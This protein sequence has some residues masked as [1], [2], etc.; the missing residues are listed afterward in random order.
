M[1]DLKIGDVK[2]GTLSRVVLGVDGECPAV[3]EAAQAGVD[4]L[5]V[6]VD[7]LDTLAPSQVVSEV[8]VLK[9]HEMPLIGTIRSQAE[10]G[11]ANVSDTQRED[12]Y[13][14]ISPLVQAID[15][16]LSSSILK[17]VIAAARR[18]KNTVI[19][20]HHNFKKT[21]NDATLTDIVKKAHGLGAD[22][23]KIAVRANDEGDVVRLLEFTLAHRG[24]NLVTI[25]MG[26]IGS[27]SRLLFPLAGS[28]MT[29]TSVT[30][31]DGQ[32]PPQRLIE[33]LRLYYPR[34]NESV[35]ARTKSLEFA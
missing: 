34:Y 27:V 30:P 35:I 28:V 15:L 16:D 6:R 29:Y 33:D 32:I 5:E 24:K 21:P 3:A 10:G 20:S 11:K 1:P 12:L 22:I 31:S 2:L 23:I 19:L 17:P 18:N 4:I 14:R 13:K 7:L 26:S 9:R 25:S 8:K